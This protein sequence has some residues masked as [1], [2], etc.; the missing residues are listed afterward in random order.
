MPI[1]K[2]IQNLAQ[3]IANERIKDFK[4]KG[5]YSATDEQYKEDNINYYQNE[6]TRLKNALINGKYYTGVKSVSSSGMSRT[7]TIAYIYKNKLFTIRD[8]YILDL[9]GVNKNGRIGG[10]G[11]DMLFHAQYTLFN[12]LHNSY[13]RAH[14]QKR[15]SNYNTI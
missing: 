1:T 9:A 6:L 13:K 4:K 12:N 7:I 14:Y 8:K 2:H 11:M 10:C 3:G 5:I 15:M